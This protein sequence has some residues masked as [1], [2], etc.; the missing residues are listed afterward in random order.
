M[1]LC[2]VRPSCCLSRSCIVSKRVSISSKFVQHRVTVHGPII[3][4]FPYQTLRQYSDW[5]P[6][7]RAKI[8]IFDQFLASESMTGGVVDHGVSYSI[9]GEL[10][11]PQSLRQ[12]K[13]RCITITI[14]HN[15]ACLQTR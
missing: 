10:K 8:A 12:L 14:Q 15:T 2:G 9:K 5:D 4:V 1:P 13:G 7:T 11:S 6:L 3:L